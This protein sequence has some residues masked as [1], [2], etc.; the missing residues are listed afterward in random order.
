MWTRN[1][2]SRVMR[3]VMRSLL[4]R[5][6][7]ERGRETQSDEDIIAALAES[8]PEWRKGLLRY[9]ISERR[10]HDAHVDRNA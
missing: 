4:R 1:N 8:H 3:F 6:V 10:R 2:V 5:G 7:E 9:V